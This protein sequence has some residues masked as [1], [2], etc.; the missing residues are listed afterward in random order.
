M[1]YQSAVEVYD[2]WHDRLPVDET[3]DSPWHRMVRAR[4]RPVDLQGKRVLEIGCGRGGFAA[5]LARLD[6]GP[7]E[8]VAADF[9]SAA[10]D[11]G[12][13]FAAQNGLKNLTWKV[14]DI[15]NLGE[16]DNEFDTVISFETIE[17]IPDPPQGVRELARV[18]KPG[19][20]LYLSTPN[21]LSSIGLYRVYCYLRGKT[22]DECGQPICHVTLLPKTRRWIRSAGLSIIETNSCGQ[23]LPFPGRPPIEL[24]FA[25]KPQFIMRW[26]GLHSIV[27]AQKPTASG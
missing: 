17:H 8:I 21:Y 27:V 24:R 22:F 1:S 25:E 26:F 9:S 15:Q 5:W 14:A 18:L 2:K 10:V 23:Y 7:S 16:G 11:K 4:L 6:A 3:A 19:G 13:S 12:R 20:R